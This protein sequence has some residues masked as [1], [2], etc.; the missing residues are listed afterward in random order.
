MPVQR[1]TRRASATVKVLDMGM[2]ED[3][4][5]GRVSFLVEE[6]LDGEVMTSILEQTRETGAFSLNDGYYYAYR[7]EIAWQDSRHAE[8]IELGQ[9][10]ATL[11]VGD[12]VVFSFVPMCGR[13]APC[14]C[15]RPVL[16]E[17]GAASNAGG[18]LPGGAMRR[19]R[20]G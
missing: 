6:W 11:R 20:P 2:H 9:D 18:T 13:C 17:P 15:G 4:V 12:Q 1:S 10:V 19:A 3:I 5:R 16:C 8:V 14:A 7:T